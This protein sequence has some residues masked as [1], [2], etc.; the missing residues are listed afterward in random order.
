[1]VNGRIK[2]KALSNMM[3]DPKKNPLVKLNLLVKRGS[4]KFGADLTK[5]SNKRSNKR[6]NKRSNQINEKQ[7]RSNKKSESPFSFFNIFN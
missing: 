3:K 7:K 1:M 6:A 2:S 4:K 5:R